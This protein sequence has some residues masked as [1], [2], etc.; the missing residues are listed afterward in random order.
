MRLPQFAAYLNPILSILQQ[1][2][3]SARPNEVV[4]GVATMLGVPDALR[5]ERLANGRT[6][7]F[8]NQVH[9]ARFFLAESGYIDRSRRGVWTLTDKGRQIAT[10]TDAEIRRILAEVRTRTKANGTQRTTPLAPETAL[11]DVPAPEPLAVDYR[12]HLLEV[13]RS[14]PPAGFERLCQRLLRASG[15]EQVTVTGRSGDG[16]IDGDGLL[17]VNRFVSFRVLFQCK[18]Y[19][20]SVGASAVRDFRGAMMGRTDKGMIITTGT[21]T[22]DARREARRDGAPPIELV[23]GEQLVTL[24]EELELGLRPRT[25]YDVDV[26]FFEDYRT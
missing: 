26:T 1:L 18:R 23:D 5:E 4:D 8:D 21:F 13:I 14:L 16:G 7:R 22:P 12:E 25:T 2:G 3:G 11:E 17:V 19:A 15:F 6:A 10:L 20:G 24:F 9:W